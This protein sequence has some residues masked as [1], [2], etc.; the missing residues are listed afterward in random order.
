MMLSV[1]NLRLQ[2]ESTVA[3]DMSRDLPSLSPYSTVTSTSF[4]WVSLRLL[5][6]SSSLPSSQAEYRRG[7]EEDNLEAMERDQM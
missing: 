3:W 4:L 5:L 7:A 2:H 6:D 1:Y